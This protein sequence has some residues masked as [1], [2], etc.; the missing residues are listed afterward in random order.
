M[1]SYEE[2]DRLIRES[3]MREWATTEPSEECFDFDD[4]RMYELLTFI[5]KTAPKD[6]RARV[7]LHMLSCRRCR[8]LYGVH[9]AAELP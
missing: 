8:Y 6:I 5:R 9:S 2:L 4:E 7:C 1:I 3:M